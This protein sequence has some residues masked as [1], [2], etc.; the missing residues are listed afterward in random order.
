[1]I[2][3]NSGIKINFESSDS[4]EGDSDNEIDDITVVDDIINDENEDIDTSLLVERDHFVWE[5]GRIRWNK[6]T[7]QL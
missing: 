5:S 3:K 6:R 1:M 2:A 7:I 4:S